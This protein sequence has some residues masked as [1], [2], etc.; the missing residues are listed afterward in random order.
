MTTTL[1]I[2]TGVLILLIVVFF[3]IASFRR[4]GKVFGKYEF[5][6]SRLDYKINKNTKKFYEILD[7][8]YNFFRFGIKDMLAWVL[9][10]LLDILHLITRK[11]AVRIS[12]LRSSYN[13][14]R[15]EDSKKSEPSEYLREVG[16]S[17]DK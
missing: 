13:R 2:I 10:Y 12:R 6:I 7:N 1:I 15:V 9:K 16:E 8:I 5:I 4:K 11:I 14:R 17:K 3:V